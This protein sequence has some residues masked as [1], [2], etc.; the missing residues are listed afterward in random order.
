LRVDD[1]TRVE[2]LLR[3]SIRDP[4]PNLR[5]G[6]DCVL[7]MAPNP[8]LAG[9]AG[10]IDHRLDSGPKRA[11][12]S[13]QIC[14]DRDQPLN[15]SHLCAAFKFLVTRD[16]ALMNLTNLVRLCGAVALAW[17]LLAMGVGMSGIKAR[18]F[19]EASYFLPKPAV[20]EAIAVSRAQRPGHE[21]FRLVDRST[22]KT[23]PFPLPE[24]ERWGCL[25]VSPW[26]DQDGDLE[27]VGRWARLDPAGGRAY[28]GLG[29]FRLSNPAIVHRIE[30]DLLP[31]GKPCWV[32]GRPGDFVFPAGDGQLHR[33]HLSRATDEGAKNPSSTRERVRT[34]RANSPRPVVWQCIEPGSGRT[35]MTDPVWPCEK[36]LQRF[37]FVSLSLQSTG[38]SKRRLEPSRIW[39]LEMSDGGYEVVSAGPLTGQHPETRRSDVERMPNVTVGPSGR[40]TL[41][42]LRR[43][44]GDTSWRL[45]VAAL[46]LEKSTGKPVIAPGPETI[47]DVADELVPSPPT[48]ST[49]GQAVFAFAEG[50]RIKRYSLPR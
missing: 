48:F 11:V 28:C 6:W 9:A 5:L 27:A 37:I 39:W 10:E 13:I 30:L 17:V 35:F 47:R 22:G 4:A 40:P 23:V 29:L 33:C 14:D 21:E 12:S 34:V 3:I 18:P 2:H 44:K 15:S 7:S 49:D 31:T 16:R 43:A 36:E 19:P 25:S 32:P 8:P 42:Y 46:S 24:D 1:R 50:G 45:C 20:H 38:E 41:A 26:R